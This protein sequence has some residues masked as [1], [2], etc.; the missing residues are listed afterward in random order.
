MENSGDQLLDKLRATSVIASVSGRLSVCAQK[1][2]CN[3][4]WQG[5]KQ[6]RLC[7]MSNSIRKI[8][9]TKNLNDDNCS[10]I[11][12]WD[13]VCSEGLIWCYG[14]YILF[15]D[16]HVSLQHKHEASCVRSTAQ[17]TQATIWTASRPRVQDKDTISTL[18]AASVP[19]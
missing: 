9:L 7:A 11:H 16:I 1:V 2:S 14:E 13:C 3:A 12:W 8:F 18:T 15:F 17:K 4:A 19:T 6:E 5:S 10:A